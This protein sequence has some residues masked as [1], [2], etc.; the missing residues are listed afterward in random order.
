MYI[1]LGDNIVDSEEIVSIIEANSEFAV[2]KDLTKGTKREDVLAYQISIPV[3]ELNN[4]IKEN[5]DIEEIDEEEL[6]DEYMTLA[7]E[8]AMAVED[9][10][11]ED[12]IINTRAYKW[13]N[14]DDTVKVVI[15][16]AHD[17]LGE[18]KLRDVTRRLLNQV[19]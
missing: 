15:A 7:D 19:D 6:F 14:S 4:I 10:M 8:L 12:S 18:L 13:D 16:I 17:E 9:Y 5:Y 2:E 3:E 11:D 1:V